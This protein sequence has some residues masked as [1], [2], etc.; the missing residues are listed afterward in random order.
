M[1]KRLNDFEPDG[2]IGYFLYKR[3]PKLLLHL[4]DISEDE[5]LGIPAEEWY[6]KFR[7]SMWEP[8]DGDGG[9]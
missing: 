7:K 3:F 4:Y 9:G 5:S 8:L 6:L 2:Y 1:R